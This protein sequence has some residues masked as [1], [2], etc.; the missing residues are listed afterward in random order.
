[1]DL[2]QCVRSLEEA[3]R[4]YERSMEQHGLPFEDAESSPRARRLSFADRPSCHCENGGASIWRNWISPACLAC[5]A[6]KETGSLFV[7]LKCTKNC[8]FCFNANQPHFEHFQAHR[9]DIVLELEQ[10]HAAGAKY[11]CLAVTGGEPLLNEDA[12]VAF[13]HRARELYPAAH[14]RLYTNGEL[15]NDANLKQLADA[16]LREIRFSVKPQDFDSGQERVFAAMG[17]AVA[18]LPDVVIEM[19]V[20]PGSIGEMR[21]TIRRADD[22]GVRGMNLLELCFPLR[23][24]KEFRRRGMKL[25]KR[26]FNYPY[27][28]WYGGGIPVAESERGGALDLLEFADDRK[29]RIGIHYC[30]TDNRNSAQ[31]SLQNSPFENAEEVRCHYAWLILDEEDHFLKCAKAF[32]A[33]AEDVRKW[34]EESTDAPCDYDGAECRIAFPLELAQE[35]RNA[36]P[37]AELG[38]SSSILEEHDGTLLLREV[39][40][41]RISPQSKTVRFPVDGFAPAH[42]EKPQDAFERA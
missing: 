12:V 10:A 36:L 41:K 33:D 3:E 28:Y 38:L 21:D 27:G 29:L 22:I 37:D 9:R 1:M 32:G 8:Y 18:M 40:L 17:R 14:T 13:Y 39:G 25:R 31:V 19:P 4:N 16:G 35:V 30:S 7:D 11:R 34:L 2:D 26:P 20:I 24:A 5:R 42:G 15:L 6:G 23:N